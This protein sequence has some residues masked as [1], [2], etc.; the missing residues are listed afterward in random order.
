MKSDKISLHS[1]NTIYSLNNIIAFYNEGTRCTDEGRTVHI[2]YLNFSVGFKTDSH[3]FLP[4]KST[5]YE[6]DKLR[7]QCIENWLS[8]QAQRTVISH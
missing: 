6:L 3:N 8:S 5:K 1:G 4:D 7:V 2:T